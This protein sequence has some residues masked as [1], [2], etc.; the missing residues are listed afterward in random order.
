MSGTR[1]GIDVGG[2][3]T[4]LVALG[5]R[6]VRVVKVPSTPAAPERALWDAY[7]AAELS[8]PPRAL[9]HGTTVATNALLERK[10]ARVALVLTAGFEDL[11]ELRRQDRA[12]L[13]DLSR[14]HPPPLV[15]RE[16]VVGLRER[17]GPD[18]PVL[19][20]S[21]DAVADAVAQVRALADGSVWVITSQGVGRWDG[22]A[23]TRI[24]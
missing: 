4:D 17:M 6:G 21:A 7:H 12:A 22:Q 23:W 8:E 1:V 5:G 16:R 14:H 18:G 11:L 13:Y 15:P 20:L 24:D 10:G 2:T 3:F 19:P 9:V